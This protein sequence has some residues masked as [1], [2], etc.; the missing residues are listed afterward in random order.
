MKTCMFLCFHVNFKH[1]STNMHVSMY[2][3]HLVPTFTPHCIIIVKG[4]FTSSFLFQDSN[5]PFGLVTRVPS[6]S[7]ELVY[8]APSNAAVK[9]VSGS[10]HVTILTEQGDIF[11]FGCGE[12]GQLGRVPECFSSR[13][14]R[15]GI[16]V[17]LQPQVV[18]FKKARGVPKPI[19]GDVF[20][21]LHSTFAVTQ[22][23]RVYVWGLNNYG[24]LGTNDLDIRF[25]PE[26]LPQNWTEANDDGERSP[27]SRLQI[28]GGQHHTLLCQDGSVFVMGRADYGRLGLGENCGERSVP[29]RV[30]DMASASS[31][32]AGSCCSFSVTES[33][34]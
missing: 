7:P 11:T 1:E 32:A 4:L 16:S 5:G 26:R 33:G 9:V 34:E 21:G 13:G 6:S 3:L 31:V 12:Q 25:Q 15:K 27:G 17:L 24:Q 10:D 30:P 2:F 29:T 20:C 23:Q 18:R 14:G 8:S 22:D 28:A 19:F